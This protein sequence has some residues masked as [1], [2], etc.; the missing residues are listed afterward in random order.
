[1]ATCETCQAQLL[2][3]L[4][5]VLDDAE[6]QE[7]Q[8][9][10]DGCSSCQT[11]LERARGQQR[12]LALWH[13]TPPP[14]PPPAAWAAT[15]G[16]VQVGVRTARGGRRWLWV[17]SLLTTAAVLFVAAVAAWPWQ[18]QAVPTADAEPMRE[19]FAVA[20]PDEIEIISIAA[21]DLGALVVGHPPLREPRGVA[22]VGDMNVESSEPGDDGMVPYVAGRD[23]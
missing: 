3:Y 20:S 15:L 16:R 13:V 17:A 7:L 14:D 2:E 9:H 5:D 18:P 8:Q 19:P 12:L 6:R 11:A 1:M 22:A 10:L 4:Y 21:A 23:P